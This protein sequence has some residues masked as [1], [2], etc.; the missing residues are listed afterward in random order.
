MAACYVDPVLCSKYG[1]QARERN[2]AFDFNVAFSDHEKYVRREK[3]KG[4]R[5]YE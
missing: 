3:E 1:R 5:G 2:K 4:N